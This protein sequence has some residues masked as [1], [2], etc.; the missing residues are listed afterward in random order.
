MISI[1]DDRKQFTVVTDVSQGGSSLRSGQLELM[2]HRRVQAD[3][4][5]GVQEP[6]NETMCGC[7]DQGAAPGQMGE[8]GSEGDGGCD[9][10]GLTMRGRHFVIFDTHERA[11]AARRVANEEL[12]SPATIGINIGEGSPAKPTFSAVSQALPPNIKLQTL[13]GNYA[14]LFGGKLVLRLAHLF[15]VDEH[16]EYSRPTS[17]SLAAVFGSTG[18]KVTSVEEMS[19]TATMTLEAMDAAKTVWP[20]HDTTEGKMWHTSDAVVP[21]TL[22]AKDDPTLTVTLRPMELRTLL[23]TL[24]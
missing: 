12:Q 20:T 19:L 4:H 17:V 10:E 22:M 2:V 1:E 3:D 7:N 14:E 16:I 21:R 24:E 23:V 15:A 5:R 13:T 18:L 11:N 8:H 6:L 9:C